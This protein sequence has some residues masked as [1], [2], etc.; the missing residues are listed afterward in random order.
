[1]NCITSGV[2]TTHPSGVLEIGLSTILLLYRD[3]FNWWKKTA[4]FGENNQ[5]GTNTGQMLSHKFV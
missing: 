1:M 2:G 5:P 4:V 3:L